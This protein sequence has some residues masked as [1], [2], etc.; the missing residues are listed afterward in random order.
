MADEYPPVLGDPRPES[1]AAAEHD[2][3]PRMGRIVTSNPGDRRSMCELTPRA[4]CRA[5]ARAG[6]EP[7]PN[8][9]L[10]LKAEPQ[11][12]SPQQ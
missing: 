4:R 9:I 6:S 2:R 5:Y 10:T 3:D 1:A 8:L 7:A 12:P 11:A